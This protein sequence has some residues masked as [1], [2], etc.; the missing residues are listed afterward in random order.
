V[1][2]V[3]PIRRDPLEPAALHAHAMDNLR[4]IR[5]TI[6]RAGSFTA[7]PGWGGVA[8]GLSAVSAALAGV[9]W[10]G[11]WLTVWLC[12]AVVAC[13]IG[14]LT[15]W[16]KARGAG[17]ALL[18]GPGRKFLMG[19]M[20]PVAA[21]A[22]LTAALAGAGQTA[23]LPGC[24]MLLYG[25][26][27]VTGGSASVR[28]VPLM[29]VCFMLLGAAALFAPADWANWMLAAGF[30]SLHIVFGAVIAVKYGG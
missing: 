5:E 28:P 9:A 15:A 18:A 14:W 8:I 19:L 6:E 21:G 3:K 22:A 25:A 10:P 4:Y 12:E 29:G 13:A 20:P 23:W 16:L 7:V 17:L 2:L 11:W 27:I 30:G 1:A 26:G 24:W